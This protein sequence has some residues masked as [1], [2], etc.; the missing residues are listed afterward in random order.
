M[1]RKKDAILHEELARNHGGQWKTDFDMAVI[2]NT[3]K[4]LKIKYSLIE[5][6][7]A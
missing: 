5:K 1:G 6:I 2:C 4:H 7:M 3:E